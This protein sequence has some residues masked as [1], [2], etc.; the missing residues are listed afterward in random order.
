MRILAII[1]FACCMA[2][3]ALNLQGCAR[4]DIHPPTPSLKWQ[5]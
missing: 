2:M 5:D 3:V 4:S 1:I